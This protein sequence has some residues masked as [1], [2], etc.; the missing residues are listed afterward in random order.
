MT[1][2]VLGKISSVQFGLGGYQDAM[3]GLSISFDMKGSGVATFVSGGWILER[4][5]RTKWTEEDRVRQQSELCTKIIS[6]L[7]QANVN[8]VYKLRGMPVEITLESNSLV[9]WR[10]LTEVL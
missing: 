2:K 1:E 8:D 7:R 4:T 9:D 5:E 10:I 3:L 6:I